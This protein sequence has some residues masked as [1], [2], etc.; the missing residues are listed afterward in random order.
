M[1]ELMHFKKV[2]VKSQ[3]WGNL[4]PPSIRNIEPVR[5][6]FEAIEQQKS[7]NSFGYPSLPNT[8]YYFIIS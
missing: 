4:S 1:Y 3:K 6:V 7:P 5:N 8:I 2:L